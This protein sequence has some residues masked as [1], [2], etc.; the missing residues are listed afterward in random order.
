M[1]EA[2]AEA[3]EE[4]MN[5]YLEEGDLTEDEIKTALRQRTIA[6]EIVPMMC[7]TAFKNKGVQA[8]LDGVIEYLP[9]PMDIPPVSGMDEDDEPTTRK[10]DDD[11]KFA[12]LAFKIMTDPFVGQLIFF[13]VYSGTIK[14]GDTVFN[15][16][17]NKKERLGRIL[18]MH[19]NQRE[20]IKEVRAG[21]I[22]AAV[23][24]KDAT[25]G[26]TL[27]DPS[28][29][30]RWRSM[31]FPEP[32]IS[33]GCRAK[34]QGRP[35]KNGPGAE[36]PGT[37]RS[38]VPR[39]D[40]RRI[41][42]DHHR[43]YGRAA[44]GNYRRPHEARIR[45]RSDRRQATGC[46]PRNDSQDVCEESEGKF[47]KQSGGRGQYGHVVLKIEPQ[48]PGKGFEFVDAIKGGIVPR[49]YIPAVE[50]GVRDTLNTGVL[51]GYPVVD[52]KVTLF[53]GS[54]HDVDSNENAF[55]MAASM[56]FKDGCRK[57]IASHP[58]ADDGRGS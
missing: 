6:S 32:V 18:Q 45:R 40:R 34:D 29:S 24:L 8:M 51:A 43:W 39:Q 14:S 28:R 12:A 9:S 30:S 36:P 57:A 17:K 10:A 11:E 2:A 3:T 31:V 23:G 53:F 56:A 50:K 35:G 52:V 48:E 13:R 21:D 46:L 25:T 55:Q 27:C 1:V 16:I 33:A 26:E 7:G 15:P 19:A 41:R 47:V 58:R 37:G 54:Y 20:E 44:P 49:E 38:V 4:L 5:K 22:A 42:P